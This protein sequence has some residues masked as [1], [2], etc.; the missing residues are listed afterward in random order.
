MSGL[1]LI[2]AVLTFCP[3]RL[4]YPC[5]QT[6]L[7]GRKSART[8]HERAASAVSLLSRLGPSTIEG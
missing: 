6:R 2:R 1:G 3:S 4:V 8:G 5:F 7:A